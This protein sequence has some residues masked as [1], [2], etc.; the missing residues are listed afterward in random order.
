MKNHFL[1]TTVLFFA[2][3][4]HVGVTNAQ[5]NT[6][7]QKL[8]YKGANKNLA[9]MV[10][11]AM[12]FGVAVETVEQLNLKENKINFEIVM[13]GMLAKEIVEKAEMKSVMERAVAAG[14]KLVV[15]EYALDLL[16]VDKS[17]VDKRISITPNAWVYMF[18]LQDKGF[19]TLT[20]QP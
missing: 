10:T 4:I 13:V 18:E 11:D 2:L 9:V 16:G 7:N 12:H 17:K 14:A 19:N 6:S 8:E 5:V 20:I 1:L 15:C 3:F